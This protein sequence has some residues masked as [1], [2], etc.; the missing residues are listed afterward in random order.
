MSFPPPNANQYATGGSG[1]FRLNTTLTSDGDMYSSEQGAHG[2]AIGPDSDISKVNIAYFDAQV[3]RRMNQIAIS[4][5][6]PFP[7][8]VAAANEGG[9]YVPSN[10]PGRILIWPDEIY[11][12]NWLPGNDDTIPTDTAKRVD[13]EVPILDVIEYFS[14]SPIATSRNDKI[15]YMQD[16]PLP[17]APAVAPITWFYQVPFY[18][19]RYACVNFQPRLSGGATVSL[20][21]FG[22]VYRLL[23]D[24]SDVSIETTLIGSVG[25]P[26]GTVFEDEITSSTDGT[27][28]AI[29]VA[30]QFSALQS[31]GGG[32]LRILVS[33]REA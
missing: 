26:N 5:S 33:D 23:G 27:Y 11:N 30:L 15:Y 16:L 12:P 24:Q 14:P 18:G 17:K 21:A 10:R 4:P 13:I 25:V 2:F 29:Y 20:S 7:G 9:L 8:F 22:V 6:R 31:L 1:F 3:D 28:D 32:S 19:R